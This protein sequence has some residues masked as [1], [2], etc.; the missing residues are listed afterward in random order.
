MFIA[1]EF[2]DATTR[3]EPSSELE[4]FACGSC[5]KEN[6]LIVQTVLPGT[7]PHGEVGQPKS[8]ELA[9]SLLVPDYDPGFEQAISEGHLTV[10]QAVERGDRDLLA[11]NIAQRHDLPMHLAFDVVD[12]RCSTLAAIQASG[13]RSKPQ[14]EP[15]DRRAFPWKVTVLGLAGLFSLAGWLWYPG[16]QDER[17]ESFADPKRLTLQESRQMLSAREADPTE[18]RTDHEG[19]VTQ[20]IGA[21]AL[22]VLTAYCESRPETDSPVVPVEVVQ[23]FSDRSAYLVGVFRDQNETAALR[24]IAIRE[25]PST[26]RWIAGNGKKPVSL[27]DT[28]RLPRPR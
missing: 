6:T 16:P 2:C 11:T 3:V 28:V 22:S 18:I 27:I 19:Q 12:N 13:P 23:P 4:S 10:R 15:R 25:E 26:H 24:G 17:A 7:L 20:V 8:G 21:D 9:E 1:C 5:G 14:P